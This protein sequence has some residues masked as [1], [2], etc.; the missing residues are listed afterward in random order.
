[1][2]SCGRQQHACASVL[3]HG[4]QAQHPPTCL[5]AVCVS[6]SRNQFTRLKCWQQ[7]RFVFYWTSAL[8][9]VDDCWKLKKT[10]AN[11]DKSARRVQKSVKVIKHGSVRYVWYSFLLVCYSNFILKTRRFWDTRLQKISCPW[12]SGQRLF[13]VI[14]SGTI[15]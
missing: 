5:P 3:N 12:N 1:M 6:L 14:Y 11:V 8:P 9:P 15:W 10:S 7:P 4:L 13:K 2:F